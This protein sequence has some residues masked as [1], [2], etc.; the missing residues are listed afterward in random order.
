MNVRDFLVEPLAYL[1]PARALEALTPAD[2]DRRFP[3]AHH[4]IAEI[5]AHMT[6]WQDWFCQRCDGVDEPMAARAADGWPA[7]AAGSW[8][9]VRDR[10]LQG[11]DRAAAIGGDAARLDRAITP[12][13]QFPPIAEYTIRDA[14][15]HMGSHNAHHMGQI[16]LL[17]QL[18]DSW[19]PPSGSW[20]W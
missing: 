14:L 17:R 7:V 11:L 19:P 3:G 4:S 16:I 9:A 2:A 18:M 1:A 20:T 6:F 8:P 12:A 5:V 13:I 10:F 15:V